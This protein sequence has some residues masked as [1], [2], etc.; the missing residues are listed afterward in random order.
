MVN[1]GLYY[2]LVIS[3]SN[4]NQNNKDNDEKDE[5]LAKKIQEEIKTRTRS[6]SLIQRR[7]S[8]LSIKSNIS[9]ISEKENNLIIKKS[10]FH[11]PFLFQ[12]FKL[13]KPEWYYLL[14]G[15]IA[16]LLFGALMPVNFLLLFNKII[17]IFL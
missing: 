8:I 13:N 7:Q 3:Q 2:E 10:F 12:I 15:G 11:L 16:S 9:D 14:L 5:E 4:N 6:S 17:N 1:K